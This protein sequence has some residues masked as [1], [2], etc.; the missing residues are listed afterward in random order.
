MGV[1]DLSVAT[2]VSWGGIPQPRAGNGKVQGPTL[3]ISCMASLLSSLFRRED[4]AGRG[5]SNQRGGL[6]RN[7]PSAIG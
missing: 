6:K 3:A 1:L 2:V 4:K 5:A 7:N